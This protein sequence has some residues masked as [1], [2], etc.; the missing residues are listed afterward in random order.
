[1]TGKCRII[2]LANQKGGTGKTTTTSNL[3]SALA[4]NG[5]RVL[6]V[7]LDPQANLSMSFGIDRPD[8]LKISMNDMLTHIVKAGLS[9]T[10]L[11]NKDVY[12]LGNGK[13]DIIPSNNTLSIAESNLRNELGA[14]HTL[15]E[16][17]EP[18]SQDYDYII[19]DT[20]PSL[21]LLTINALT[22]CNEV[23]IPVSTQLWSITG[24]VDLVETVYKVKK[25]LN[26]QINI[27]GIVLTM[28]DERTLLYKKASDLIREF[29][30]NKIRIFN[31]RIPSTVDVG[32]ANYVSKSVIDFNEGSKAAHA[33]KAFAD[34]VIT[35]G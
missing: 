3:G 13:F 28:C 30:E 29:C 31:T 26:K 15:S 8:E 25:K 6:L 19:I 7:D 34:E 11:P 14:E 22:A 32:K 2:A 23:I 12:I 35:H 20:S 21:G 18:L 5:K 1:M 9:E 27:T 4:K 17:L 10:P 16:L 24:L 33:Y